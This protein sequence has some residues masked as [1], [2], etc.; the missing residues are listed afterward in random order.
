MFFEAEYRKLLSVLLM[1]AFPVDRPII[2]MCAWRWIPCASAW[3][4]LTC[5]FPLDVSGAL[6]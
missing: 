2:A 6:R 3:Y 5:L 4:L 1:N